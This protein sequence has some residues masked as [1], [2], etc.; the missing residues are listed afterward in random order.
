MHWRS[1]VVLGLVNII[2]VVDQ[3][4][5]GVPGWV[6]VNEVMDRRGE[7]VPGPV[8]VLE[9]VPRRAKIIFCT[10]AI[11]LIFFYITQLVPVAF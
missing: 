4:G 8:V 7:V 6:N 9:V 5:D 11:L 1:E 3:R 10:E 2:E